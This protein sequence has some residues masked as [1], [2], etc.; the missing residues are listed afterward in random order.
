MSTPKYLDSNGVAFLWNQAKATFSAKSHTHTMSNISDLKNQVPK[1]ATR[2]NSGYDLN[3]YNS[4]THCGYYYA[5]GSNNCL[6]KPSGVDAFGLQ[7]VKNADGYI[8]QILYASNNSKN[9]IYTRVYGGGA[10]TGWEKL[11]Q[12]GDLTWSNISGKPSTYPPNTH[13]HSKLEAYTLVSGDDIRISI[14]NYQEVIDVYLG[15]NLEISQTE[16][17]I[18]DDMTFEIAGSTPKCYWGHLNAYKIREGNR[19]IVSYSYFDNNGNV[20]INNT[21]DNTMYNSFGLALSG[22]SSSQLQIRVVRS[23]MNYKDVV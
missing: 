12:S 4:S 10:W 17:E 8:M 15:W 18:F 23:N 6:S 16:L 1:N 9:D 22:T 7:I 21:T 11:A 5:G 13:R 19:D 14:S 3:N 2:V 20:I